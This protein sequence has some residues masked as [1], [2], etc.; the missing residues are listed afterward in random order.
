MRPS[1]FVRALIVASLLLFAPLAM[2]SGPNIAVL[3]VER[4]VVT[5]N[6]GKA[7]QKKLK[8]MLDRK[9]KSLN[10][11]QEEFGK[12]QEQMARQA[13]MMTPEKKRQV[14]EELQAEYMQLQEDFMKQQQELAKM[15]LDLLQPVFKQL[16]GVLAKIAE[17]KSLDMIFGKGQQGVLWSKPTYDITELA[18]KRLN[19]ATK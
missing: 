17:E 9:Q 10:K 19:A 16:E 13:A 14:M 6:A 8:K 18:L 5:S 4:V 7:M 2:A 15:E 12:K 11:R 1:N 3:D